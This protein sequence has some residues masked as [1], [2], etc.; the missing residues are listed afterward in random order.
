MWHK[1][2]ND[3]KSADGTGVAYQG[4]PKA[5]STCCWK[6]RL[7]S[8]E[9]SSAFVLGSVLCGVHGSFFSCSEALIGFRI[10][11]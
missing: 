2:R 9:M 4:S 10:S 6:L 8:P 11:D 5:F 3:S 1:V 7:A